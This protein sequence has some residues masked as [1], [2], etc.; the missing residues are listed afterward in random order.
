MNRIEKVMFS[1]LIFIFLWIGFIAY[2]Y[3]KPY[4]ISDVWIQPMP[5]TTERVK[6]WGTLTY[7]AEYCRYIT[8]EA[9]VTKILVPAD[10]GSSIL[11]GTDPRSSLPRTP[12]D[13][14]S[15]NPK[16]VSIGNFI[17]IDVKPWIYKLEIEV[18]YPIL[19]WRTDHYTFQTEEFEIY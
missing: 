15:D 16:S 17:P 19:P 13:C 1:A 10:E 3:I 14:S 12:R 11:L 18:K 7:I 4:N 8:V 9:D 2:L 5:V 6:A